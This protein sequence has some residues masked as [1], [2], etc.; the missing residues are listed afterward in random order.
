MSRISHFFCFC[1]FILGLPTLSGQNL[2]TGGLGENIFEEGDFGVG[3][4][5]LIQT[6][7]GIAP[8][9]FYT[10]TVPP[11]DGLY[12]ITNNTGAWPDLYSTWLPIGDNSD[13][14]NGYMMVVNASFTPGTFFEQT[15]DGLCA[16]TTYEFSADIIN[17]IRV[18]VGAHSAPNV[19]FVL[20]GEVQF[21]T[22]NIP[23]TDEWNTYGF[24]FTTPPNATEVTLTLRNNAPGGIGN[25]LALDNI[26][27]RVCGS[28]AFI[29]TDQ[30][31]FLCADDNSPAP[32]TADVS[33]NDAVIQWQR[34]IDEGAT[35]DDLEGENESVYFHD[36]FLP[37][38]YLYRYL[39]ASTFADLST[40]KCRVVSP[41]VRLEVLPITFDIIDTICTGVPYLLGLDTLTESGIYSADLLSSKGCDS[42][43]TVDLTVVDNNLEFNFEA[44][45]PSC[46][47]TPD[48]VIALHSFQ[49]GQPGYRYF[50]NGQPDTTPLFTDLL[51]GTYEIIVEDRYQC[52]SARTVE[53]KDNRAFW[54]EAGPDLNLTFGELSNPVRV[55]SIDPIDRISWTPADFLDCSDCVNVQFNGV[56]DQLYQIEAFD[57]NG[58]V[59]RDSLRV[60]V[61]RQISIYI[62]NTFSPNGDGVNDHFSLF[63]FGQS[64]AQINSL[65]IFNRWG[66]L[67]FEARN[68]P[69]NDLL[70]GWDGRMK[71][72][73]VQS[74]VYTYV[75][76]VQ[77]IDGELLQKV[78]SVTV[79]L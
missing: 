79:L 64:V 14:P 57:E 7:P 15:V 47:E 29:D 76:D 60:F 48:G 8:G 22:G 59:A 45:V 46:P 67:V 32:I 26:S 41:E 55:Q 23:Q 20:D 1:C 5:N 27:F 19:S 11:P 77:L 69:A 75:F 73:L 18:G 6:D 52:R 61:D 63:A 38:V 70:A 25:D 51:A 10:L 56:Q 24:T 3:M 4:E 40:L 58:C 65:K 31:I 12:T 42:M 43:V 35:W 68:I 17:L 62:P 50:F 13:D 2:C 72:S 53:L 54:I 28:A 37:G 71:G 34:S 33:L 16:N 36:L 30:T 39:S 66:A 49:G 44:I 74:G 21:T 9:Y 78:G